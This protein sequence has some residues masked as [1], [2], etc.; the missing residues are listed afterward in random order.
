MKIFK[1][2]RMNKFKDERFGKKWFFV[3]GMCVILFDI[4]NKLVFYIKSW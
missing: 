1:E 3:F 2:I 4:K